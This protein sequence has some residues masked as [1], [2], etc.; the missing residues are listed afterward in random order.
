M[1]KISEKVAA[2]S[3]IDAE[4][5]LG[6][7]NEE[8]ERRNMCRVCRDFSEEARRFIEIA[9]AAGHNRTAIARKLEPYYGSCESAIERHIKR[10]NIGR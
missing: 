9:V 4:A 7:L 2:E 5:L 6:E 1:D 8:R 10:H 3:F